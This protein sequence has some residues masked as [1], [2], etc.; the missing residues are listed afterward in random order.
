[1]S[2]KKNDGGPSFTIRV[3]DEPPEVNTTLLA[4]L[5]DGEKMRPGDVRGQLSDRLGAEL[6]GFMSEQTRVAKHRRAAVRGTVTLAIAFVSGPDGSHSY[7][8]DSKVKAAKIPPGTS[9]TF[10]DDDGELTG[11]PVEPLT[12]EMYRRE[13]AEQKNAA[14]PKVGAAS[15]L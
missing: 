13:D 4:L 3:A 7:A 15:K 6:Q 12:A 9:M 11:R 14:E 8:V 2:K 1:M 10:A 5:R